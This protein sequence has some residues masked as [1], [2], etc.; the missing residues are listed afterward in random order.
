MEYPLWEVYSTNTRDALYINT[1]H[2][3]MWNDFACKTDKCVDLWRND[4]FYS[5]SMNRIVRK[6]SLLE[7]HIWLEAVNTSYKICGESG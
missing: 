5:K 6:Y 1:I 2:K 4:V 3:Q 7:D